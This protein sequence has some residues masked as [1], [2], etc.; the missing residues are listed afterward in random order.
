MSRRTAVL[1][2]YACTLAT[3]LGGVMLG[4]LAGWQAAVVGAQT[5]AVLAVLAMLEQAG[6]AEQGGD[7]Q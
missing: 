5:A 7:G 4:R 3:G 6:K 1:V 2:I